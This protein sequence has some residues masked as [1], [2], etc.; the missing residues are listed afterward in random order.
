MSSSAAVEVRFVPE[1]DGSTRVCLEHRRPDR[2]GALR[3]QMRAI[4]ETAGDWGRLLAMF[5]RVA[6]GR[7]E[8]RRLDDVAAMSNAIAAPQMA[9]SSEISGQIAEKGA[10]LVLGE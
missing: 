1:A 3:D 9:S 5:A 8:S 10:R 2:Y 7:R 4:F 6:E